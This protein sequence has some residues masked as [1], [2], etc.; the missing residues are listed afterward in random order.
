MGYNED[1]FADHVAEWLERGWLPCGSRLIE[2]GSQEF[3]SEPTATRAAVRDFLIRQSVSEADADAAIGPHGPFRVAGVYRA[4]GIEY[5]SI[6]VDRM[7]GSTYFDLNTFCVP[8]KWV[9]YFDF[10][11][12]EGTIEHLVNPIN[13]F[14]VTH[15]MLKVGGIARHNGPL[16]GMRDHGFFYAT[17]KFY[18]WMCGENGYEV[19]KAAVRLKGPP[20]PFECPLFTTKPP[21]LA[22][23]DVAFELMYRKTRDQPFVFPA[24]HLQ[25]GPARAIAQTLNV[26]MAAYASARLHADAEV[27][28]AQEETN[29][30]GSVDPGPQRRHS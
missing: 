7:Y 14:Q 22:L 24:D 4:L 19:L 25:H 23:V 2:F 1:S 28:S 17:P 29:S 12:N 5:A 16:T 13:G 18:A 26:N 9:G 6:D 21:G 30:I 8:R 11:N 20:T 10:V 3:Y 15:D 27:G